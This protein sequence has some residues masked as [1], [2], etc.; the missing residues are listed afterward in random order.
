MQGD[1]EM[2]YSEFCLHFF[3]IHKVASLQKED[4]TFRQ[5]EHESL[6]KSRERFNELITFGPDLGFPDPL[7]L[8]HFFLGLA[9]DSKESLDLASGGAFLH[10]HIIKARPM[11][12]KVVQ[13]YSK[14]SLEEKES[15]P[16]QKEEV[17]VAKI[18]SLQ[19]QDLAINPKPSKPHND[20]LD[21]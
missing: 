10:L 21:F 13:S 14:L 2:L 3:L 19:S 15:P 7:L 16:E 8:Q 17:F 1:W 11:L 5:L 12:E 6:S 9:K 4:L 20:D 18:Q